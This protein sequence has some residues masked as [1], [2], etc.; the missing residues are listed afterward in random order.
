MSQGITAT[1]FNP[2]TV[3]NPS[4]EVFG[5]YVLLKR[6]GSG[7][8]AE[9]F[10]ARP[11]SASGNG[12]V[13]VIK[14]ILPHM[15][16]DP[17][18]V[19]MFRAEVQVMMGFSHPHT[20]QLHDFGEVNSQLF[21]AMEYI[22]GKS[23][24]QIISTFKKKNEA[25]PVPMV[26]SLIAQ[27]AAGL[28]YAHRFENKVTGEIFNAVH[29]D[30]SPQNLIL[31]YDGNLKVIDF[32]IAKA[33]SGLTEQTRTGVIKGKVAYLSPEQVL[34]NTLDGRADIFSLG[35]VAWELLTF[36][37][38]FSEENDNELTIMGKIENCDKTILPPSSVNTEIPREVDALIMKALKKHPSDRYS[39]ANEFQTAIR[40]V[41]K[42]L[43]PDYAY[44]D[45][46]ELT[47]ALFENEIARERAELRE[48]NEMA[49]QSLTPDPSSVTRVDSETHLSATMSGVLRGIKVVAPNVTE[50]RLANIE[51]LMK[52]KATG[53]HYLLIGLYIISLMA[54]KLDDRYGILD[55]LLGP[56]GN[57]QNFSAYNG[58][59]QQT[60]ARTPSAQRR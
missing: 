45:T 29:R 10:L 33:D 39:S 58:R 19:N 49:Q 22:E 55:R 11:A 8:M 18:F 52:Q 46:G 54:I 2:S 28:N 42:Q 4:F 40:G 24:K 16:D 9:V 36:K 50:S 38:P 7:G 20:V 44:A 51:A 17:V 14:R 31:S 48:L 47:R 30:I 59:A 3:R 5:N 60:S 6:I 37:R 56:P 13:M 53:R 12:R 35:I 41:M 1:L 25:I 34:G 27:A 21:I 26:L 32:G 15:A 57:Y 43:Y 23:L